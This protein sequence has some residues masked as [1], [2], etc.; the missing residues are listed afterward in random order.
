MNKDSISRV[1]CSRLKGQDRR[2]DCECWRWVSRADC[3][4]CCC[5]CRWSTNSKS[6][7]AINVCQV[8]KSC[9][10]AF[11]LS[12]TH[13]RVINT[14]GHRS[15]RIWLCPW[16]LERFSWLNVSIWFTCIQWKQSY[17]CCSLSFIVVLFT[18]TADIIMDKWLSII[19]LNR[20]IL[21]YIHQSVSV[22][23][24]GCVQETCQVTLHSPEC[25]Y[26]FIS[27]ESHCTC[28]WIFSTV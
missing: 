8:N 14:R 23:V 6:S 26:L 25:V 24:V 22:C 19:Y 4:R 7:F 28:L 11:I 1:C 13:P 3:C 2:R 12:S 15:W 5:W 10:F 18:L 16:A 21:D 20:L 17:C 9:K 27:L